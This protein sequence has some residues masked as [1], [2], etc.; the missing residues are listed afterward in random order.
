MSGWKRT[1]SSLV[2]AATTR[3]RCVTICRS[4]SQRTT[5]SPAMTP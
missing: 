3:G 5:S 2:K 1:P 4:F